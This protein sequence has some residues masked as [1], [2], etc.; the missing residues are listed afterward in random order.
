MISHLVGENAAV[1]EHAL[2]EAAKRGNI[3]FCKELV[4]AGLSPNSLDLAGNSPVHW[5]CRGGHW[6]CLK[7]FLQVFLINI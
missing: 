4:Q 7:M 3:P 1:I 5:A 6:E 2:H